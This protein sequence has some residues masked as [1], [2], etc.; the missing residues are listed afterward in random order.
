MLRTGGW[1]SQAT[2]ATEIEP[3]VRTKMT[4]VVPYLDAPLLDP[5]HESCK[6]LR[7]GMVVS[8]GENSAGII[9]GWLRGEI[10]SFQHGKSR[11][12]S[13]LLE[14]LNAQTHRM[15]TPE[16]RRVQGSH[17]SLP[18]ICL[19]EWTLKME[20]AT[21]ALAVTRDAVEC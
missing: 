14:Q 10:V 5:I 3:L 19:S 7:V 2:L 12:V 18:G 6:G 17:I 4:L 1:E 16:M 8:I 20:V 13:V 9:P 21:I 15:S 11:M